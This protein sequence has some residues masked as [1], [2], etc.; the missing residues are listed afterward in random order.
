MPE[1]I[2]NTNQNKLKHLPTTSNIQ[3]QKQTTS[4]QKEKPERTRLE[5]VEIEEG[6][7]VAEVFV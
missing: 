6:N 3:C 5:I 7:I 2:P 4:I 1:I